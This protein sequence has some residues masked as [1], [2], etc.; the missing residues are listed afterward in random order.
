MSGKIQ[1]PSFGCTHYFFVFLDNY[2]G[3]SFVYFI[4]EKSQFLVCFKAYKVLDENES[5]MK[6]RL[7][8]IWL[9]NAG[10]HTAENFCQFSISYKMKLGLSLA[11]AGQSNG[12]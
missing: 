4:S 6:H 5:S 9:H 10:E 3:M 1:I 11:Y 12:A 7:F 2:T 8:T